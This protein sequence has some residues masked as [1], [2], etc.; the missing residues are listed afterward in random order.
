MMEYNFTSS[1]A[2]AST[3][4]LKGIASEEE[5]QNRKQKKREKVVSLE[6]ILVGDL[7]LLKQT[8]TFWVRVG[9]LCV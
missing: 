7:N 5:S 1:Y 8:P 4:Q 6:A 2:F 3:L 9:W